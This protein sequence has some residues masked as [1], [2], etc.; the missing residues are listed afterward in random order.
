MLLL[1]AHWS[2]D[3][4]SS[5]F[6][7]FMRSI[8]PVVLLPAVF[9]IVAEREFGARIVLA[10]VGSY[11]IFMANVIAGL[12]AIPPSR[13]E[14]IRLFSGNSRI[15]VLRHVVAREMIPHFIVA[16]RLTFAFN[17][18]II[19][20]SEMVWGTK[21]PSIGNHVNDAM[22]TSNTPV[23]WAIILLLGG[24]GVLINWMLD[25][26]ENRLVTWREART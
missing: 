5:W 9:L 1:Y 16:L 21:D 13:V 26:V 24:V 22:S 4:V 23:A 20:V 6:L 12:R 19:V 11:P 17:M 10:V 18:I 2:F 14:T 15:A 7:G 3:A 8:P 25:F